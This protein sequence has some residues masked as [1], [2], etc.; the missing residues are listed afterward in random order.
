MAAIMWA[1]VK[2]SLMR[3]LQTIT[4]IKLRLLGPLLHCDANNTPNDRPHTERWNIQSGGYFDA[5]C[6]N[7]H[8]NLKDQSQEKKSKSSIHAGSGSCALNSS[9]NI[10]VIP[11][12][13]TIM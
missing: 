9:V 6:E 1:Q 8:D 3:S 11:I 4:V 12:V 13:I 10:S 5:N 7:S 2:Q